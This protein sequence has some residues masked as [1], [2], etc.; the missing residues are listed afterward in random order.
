MR[1]RNFSLVLLGALV[2]AVGPA[3]ARAQVVATTFGPGDS[4]LPGYTVI[5]VDASIAEGFVYG[6]GA[7]ATLSQVRLALLEQVS[8]PYTISFKE[9]SDPG[10]ALTLESWSRTVSFGGIVS[11][12]SVLAPTLDPGD[13]YWIV[14]Q[15]SWGGTNPGGWFHNDQ[16]VKDVWTDTYPTFVWTDYP[17]FTSM[18]Y[19]VTV[20]GTVTPE[21][22]T[23][24]FLATGLVGVAAAAVRRRKR[25]DT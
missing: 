9:G 20:A 11:F 1:G 7:A 24:V 3:G 25:R 12:S 8:S 10:T 15:N 13:T 18:A 21:P 19:D 23:L 5:N 2:V 16:N 4:F 6:G 14:A 22:A 17:T